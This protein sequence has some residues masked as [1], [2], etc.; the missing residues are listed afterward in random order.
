MSKPCEFM[1]LPGLILLAA[2]SGCSQSYYQLGEA[3]PK[4]SMNDWEQQP[5]QL[6]LAELGPPHRI[7]GIPGGYVM[8]WEHWKI[9]KRALGVSLGPLGA[10]ALQLDWGDAESTADF[11]LVTVNRANQVTAAS[12]STLVSK[13]GAGVALQ[14]LAGFAPLVELDDLI[15]PMP[16]HQWGASLLLPIHETLNSTS[17]PDV[18]TAG[19]EQRGTPRGAGQRT[20]ELD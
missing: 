6:L 8:G 15:T 9:E 5:L 10:D 12:R 17:S 16:Q 7:S 18:G 2:L 13:I 3:I 11:F 14:P 19:V 4:A 20:L 1:G